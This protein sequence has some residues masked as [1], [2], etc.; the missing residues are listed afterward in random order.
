MKGSGGGV[1]YFVTRAISNIRQNVSVNVLTI[2]TITLALLLLSLF[3]LVYENLNKLGDQ[4][5]SKVQVTVYFEHDLASADQTALLDQISRVAGTDRVAYVSQEQAFSRFRARLRGQESLLEGV[6]P[7][8]LPSSM[9]ISLQKDYRD[10]DSLNVYVGRLKRIPGIIDVQ[11]GEEWVQRFHSFMGFVRMVGLLLG[12]FLLI[13]VTFIVSNT[14]KLTIYARQD[15]L[16]LL[17]LVGAT[18]FFIKAPFIIEGVIQGTVGALLA[19][20]VLTGVYY[21]FLANAGII[22]TY[23]ADS[24]SFL[25]MGE[26]I[27]LLCV[28]ALL[29]FVGSI[30]SLKRFVN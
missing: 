30:S 1:G 17:R 16:E 10:A 2:G 28:G 21:A 18:R 4:W 13:T 15:E 11:F 23:R 25:S 5:S 6:T 27:A 19:L 3:L 12:L 8:I 24:L 7:D 22:L 14:I 9:E 20:L 26:I 29:G